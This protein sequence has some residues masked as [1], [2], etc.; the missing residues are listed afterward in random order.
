[1]SSKKSIKL[2]SLTPE[3]L[4]PDDD[5]FQHNTTSRQPSRS[6][7]TPSPVFS[8]TKPKNM[9]K[10]AS[11][12][13]DEVET[14]SASRLTM[15]SDFARELRDSFSKLTSPTSLNSPTSE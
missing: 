3:I 9:K 13:P 8:L 6:L 12:V 11:D 1:M 14:R 7:S 15:L 4:K 2:D 10:S 5:V